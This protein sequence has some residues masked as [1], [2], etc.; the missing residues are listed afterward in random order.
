MTISFCD[1]G[2]ENHKLLCHSFLKVQFFY[3][4]SYVENGD[5][6]RNYE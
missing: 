5:N 4:E 2:L 3:R 6:A 1:G